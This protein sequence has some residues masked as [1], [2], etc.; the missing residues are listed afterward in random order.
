MPAGRPTKYKKEFCQIAIDLM[1]EGAS[2]IEVC[3]GLDIGYDAFLDY[4]AK[5][6]EF[7]EA[8]KK[9]ELLSQ[10]WWEGK[11]RSGLENRDFNYTGWFMNMKNRFRKSEIPW[12]DKIEHGGDL[13]ISITRKEYKQ[14]K[15]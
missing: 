8:I 5:H 9:G 12:A 11:G 6:K 2:K 4:Q 13:S 15:S 3:A 7:S 14:S 10:A 1:R